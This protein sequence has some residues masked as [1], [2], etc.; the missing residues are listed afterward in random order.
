MDPRFVREFHLRSNTQF[1]IPVEQW[2]IL[3]LKSASLL[4]KAFSRK[5]RIRCRIPQAVFIT[6]SLLILDVRFTRPVHRALRSIRCTFRTSSH[7]TAGGHPIFLWLLLLLPQKRSPTKRMYDMSNWHL[8]EKNAKTKN[9]SLLNFSTRDDVVSKV[10]FIGIPGW[11]RLNVDWYFFNGLK[12][13]AASKSYL[14]QWGTWY[15]NCPRNGLPINCFL[16]DFRTIN[17]TFPNHPKTC[18]PSLKLT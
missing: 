5:K 15:S 7:C 9:R 3:P 14:K 13:Q 17:S 12:P 4:Q 1:A 6:T 8:N 2:I 18:L 16:P 11:G 10:F